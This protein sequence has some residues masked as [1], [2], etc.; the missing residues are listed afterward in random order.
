MENSSLNNPESGQVNL[1]SNVELEPILGGIVPQILSNELSEE[2]E[3]ERLRLERQVE[4]AF[5][6]AGL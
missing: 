6:E 5:Y 1:N 3:K 4:R 2:E